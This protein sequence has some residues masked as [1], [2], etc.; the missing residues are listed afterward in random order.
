MSYEVAE[1]IP[2]TNALTI[3]NPI[4]KGDNLTA[5]ER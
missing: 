2:R 3:G 1:I 5:T 4:V